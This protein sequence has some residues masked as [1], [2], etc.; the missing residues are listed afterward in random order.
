MSKNTEKKTTFVELEGNTLD[1]FS[2]GPGDTVFMHGA[3]CQKIMGAGIASQVKTRISPLFY[4]DQYDPRSPT[5]RLGSYSAVVLAQ[6]TEGFVKIGVN[7]YTQ[8]MPGANFDSNALINALRA[9]CKTM[10]QEQKEKTTVYIPKIG[11]GIG[12]A[13]WIDVRKIIREELSDFNV[14][15]G[16]YKEEVKKDK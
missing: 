12:G 14:V 1:M 10:P 8:Y 15:V 13:K 11:C 9:F 4:L 5:Q 6:D 7:L 3:N 16:I 2:E